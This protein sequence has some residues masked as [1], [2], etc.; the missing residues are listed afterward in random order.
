M[1]F[2]G[3]LAPGF[4]SDFLPTSEKTKVL[5]VMV[6]WLFRIRC[7]RIKGKRSF[8]RKKNPICDC[9]KSDQNLIEIHAKRLNVKQIQKCEIKK[10]IGCLQT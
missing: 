4:S 3:V 7:A 1:E 2:L 8:P 5:M 9:P 10:Q 6:R